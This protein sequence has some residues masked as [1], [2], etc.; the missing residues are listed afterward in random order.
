MSQIKPMI[1]M[2]DVSK[3]YGPVQ[4]LDGCSLSNSKGDVVVVCGPSGSGKSV[5][6]PYGP[7]PPL[8]RG[9]RAR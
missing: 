4:V 1:E 7:H 5:D 3:W 9:V 2:R 8:R 6:F